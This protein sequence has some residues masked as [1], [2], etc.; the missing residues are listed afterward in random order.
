MITEGMASG[1]LA[2]LA[3]YVVHSTLL[4][5]AAWTL[6]RYV[7]PGHGWR[8]TLWKA[9]LL[10]GLVT[11]GVAQ[12]S[13]WT[14]IR[15]SLPEF[16]T[17]ADGQS[18]TW[19][20][21]MRQS[22]LDASQPTG[23]VPVSGRGDRAAPSDGAISRGE[24]IAGDAILGD[25]QAASDREPILE[26]GSARVDDDTSGVTTRTVSLPFLML[27]AWLVVVAALVGRFG[28]RRARLGRLL[29]D[30]RTV[31]EAGLPEM[32]ATLRRTAGV[33]VPVRL[34]MSPAIASPMVFGSREICVPDRF[35]TDLGVEEQRAALAH[36]LGHLARRDQAWLL[37]ALLLEC[38]FFFQPLQRV[39]RRG[40]RES[41]EYM[42]DSWAVR[43]GGGRVS[44]ARCLA[45]V[46][47]WVSTSDEPA[48][49]EM[50]AMAEG[51]SPLLSRV[52]RLLD[53]D[54]EPEP[55]FGMRAVAVVTLIAVAG[56]FA[57]AVGGASNEY[58]VGGDDE[59]TTLAESDGAATVDADVD[60]D[61]DAAN[62]AQDY[63]DVTHW[64]GKGGSL[65][66]GLRW[67]GAS[68]RDVGVGSWWVAWATN[69]R[70]RRG[71]DASSDS[72]PDQWSQLNERG[73]ESLL[74]VTHDVAR[75]GSFEDAII[76]VRL[77]SDGDGVRIDRLAMR[78]SGR[79]MD[80]RGNVYWLGRLGASAS[81][82]WLR[83]RYADVQT[84]RLREAAVEAIAV[85]DAPAAPAFLRNVIETRT[86]RNLAAQAVEG[87]EW[88]SSDETV[89]FLLETAQDDVDLSIRTEA[90][91]TLGELEH[92]GAG[93]ALRN[94]I[95]AGNRRVRAEALESLAERGDTALAALLLDIALNDPD[96]S[97]R[98][99]A[100][101]LIQELPVTVAVPLLERVIAESRDERVVHEAI[102]TLA[103]IGSESAFAVI[104]AL[105]NHAVPS[106]RREAMEALLDG[107]GEASGETLLDIAMHDDDPDMRRE[108]V[109]RIGEL[110]SQESVALLRRVV[111]E[112]GDGTAE[113]QAAESLGDVGTIEALAVLDDIIER[114]PGEDASVQAVESI[115]KNFAHELAVP[116]LTRIAREHPS[117][118]VRSEALDCLAE[119]TGSS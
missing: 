104:E 37:C 7:V 8:E 35:V 20:A 43:L 54:P 106:I 3:T 19:P 74:S 87:L 76:L 11:S 59:P 66:D 65:S 107:P 26:A 71:S 46:A 31:T 68:A 55:R 81:L 85:H 79:S 61:D 105:T 91:E 57:P 80:V 97:M 60:R 92:P 86:D 111:F 34:T 27:A 44:L 83:D 16:E 64:P 48:L 25:E 72:E 109:E 116:R 52:S 41:A 6:G 56:A 113:R 14:S 22:E 93:G 42:A 73:V 67:A 115:G 49:A 78:T 47:S 51:G 30:R 62:G 69:S 102:E 94:L 4:I 77:V 38:V 114:N 63:L 39:A 89:S 1:V 98:Q 5:G 36:E 17:A 103:D 9:A 112:S 119:L 45:E 40:L 84:P 15:V 101:E 110:P 99:E 96:L 58:G 2:F 29:R 24:A 82:G 95:R 88:H 70:V 10:G 100:V 75:T 13:P 108:A 18:S 50:V 21:S 23:E 33:W 90:V 117:R 32:L 53:R 28:W 12:A 118:R